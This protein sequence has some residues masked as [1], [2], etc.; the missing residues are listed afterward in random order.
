MKLQCLNNPKILRKKRLLPGEVGYLFPCISGY[1]RF[2][3]ESIHVALRENLFMA[4]DTSENTDQGHFFFLNKSL[5]NYPLE[6][7]DDT[8]SF[9]RSH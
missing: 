1:L 9:N 4:C 7:S 3:G 6:R 5:S 8:K 2:F